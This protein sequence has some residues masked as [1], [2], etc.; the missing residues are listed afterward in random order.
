MAGRW[1]PTLNA[2]SPILF[3]PLKLSESLSLLRRAAG[4]NSVQVIPDVSYIQ[5]HA[6]AADTRFRQTIARRLLSTNIPEEELIM[7]NLMTC[8]L[9]T[10]CLC[11]LL[12]LQKT[13]S[14]SD[15]QAERE[16]QEFGG[17]WRGALEATAFS[18]TM[19]LT[20][21]REHTQWKAEVNLRGGGREE[22][23]SPHDLKTQGAEISFALRVD[24][25]DMKF[26]GELSGDTL[27][28]MAEWYRDGA[29][30]GTGK[31]RLSRLTPVGGMAES[32]GKSIKETANQTGENETEAIRQVIQHYLD[33]TDKKDAEGIKKAFH[34]DTKLLSVGKNGLNQMRLDEWWERISRIPGRVE[35]TSQVTVLEVSGLAAVVKVDFGRSKDY[36][37]LLKING[38][39]KIVSKVLSTSLN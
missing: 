31:W 13:S 22:S 2:V 17:A 6:G 15:I 33:V 32:Q 30:I 19:D 18:L 38:E 23:L 28:G 25:V 12:T 36:V 16:F 10:A 20:L 26:T 34:P 27:S 14:A 4:A 9:L 21:A 37:S 5:S 7:R 35:R 11:I 39:W 29:K 24:E 1:Q 8:G 3:P